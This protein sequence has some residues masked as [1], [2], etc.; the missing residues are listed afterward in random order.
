MP[1]P[2]RLAMV[3]GPAGQTAPLTAPEQVTV[4]AP[5]QVKP[6][7]TTSVTVA[8]FATDGP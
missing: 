1:T 4:F 6:A 2:V 7:P 5:G 8:P 3:N